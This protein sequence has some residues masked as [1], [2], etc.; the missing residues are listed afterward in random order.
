[1]T[2]L[3]DRVP[4]PISAAYFLRHKVKTDLGPYAVRTAVV[5]SG[6]KRS[7]READH[8]PPSDLDGYAIPFIQ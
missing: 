3:E 1:V 6:I 4:I 8:S 2:R 5:S 7:V